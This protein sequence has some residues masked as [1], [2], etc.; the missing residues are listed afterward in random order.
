MRHPIYSG[1]LLAFLG[2][3]AAIGEW[4]GVVGA[5]FALI[6]FWRKIHVEE[7]RMLA[8]FTEYAQ[9]KQQTAALIPLPF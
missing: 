5:A 4:R 9:Y 8:N 2:T 1:L 6:E 3:A 7:Q